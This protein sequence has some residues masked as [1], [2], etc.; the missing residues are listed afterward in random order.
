MLDQI[1]NADRSSV[2][3][4]LG[5]VA[6]NVVVERELAALLQHECCKSRKWFRGGPK[7]ERRSRGDRSPIFDARQS[8]AAAQHGFSVPV[9]A[10]GASGSVAA[11]LAQEKRIN[12]SC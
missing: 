8:V 10:D 2:V 6:S 7:V 9:N 11:D 3:W 12:A 5:Y 4:Q 1:A